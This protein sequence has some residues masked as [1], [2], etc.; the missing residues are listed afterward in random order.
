MAPMIVNQAAGDNEG[1][2]LPF[3]RQLRW[4]L[5]VSF[6]C[7]A[8]LPVGITEALTLPQAKEQAQ[9]QVFN[10]LTSVAELK[11]NQIARW[12]EDSQVALDF[13]LSSPLR[14]KLVALVADPSTSTDAQNDIN[15]I[16]KEEIAAQ[17]GDTDSGLRFRT[18]FVYTADGH[19]V[20]ASDGVIIGRVV[21]RQPYFAESLKGEYIQPPHYTVGTANLAM[22]VTQPVI[23]QQGQIVGV[24]AGELD[25][26]A[27]GKIMLARSGLGESGETYLVSVEN[28]YLLTPSRF[29]GYPLT[30]AY[31]SQGIDRALR[32]EEGS[33]VYTN[34]RDPFVSVFGVYRWVP[35]LQAALLTE[36]DVSE[37]LSSFLQ[38]RNLSIAMAAAAILAAI[39]F[40]LFTATRVSDPISTLTRMAAR[41][42]GGDLSQ[43]THI[44][45]R[46]EIG[47]LA[48]VFNTMT[49][50]LQETQ[51]SLERRV[52]ERTAEL[53]QALTDLE[54]TLAELR[55]TASAREQLSAAVREMSSPVVPVLEGILITPLIGIID[56]SRAA[57]L[58]RSLLEAIEQH[59]ASVVILD[60]TGVPLV[61]TQTARVL[62]DAA[63][64]ARL[65]GAESVL[66]GL[67]PELAQTIVGLGVDLSGLTTCADLQSGVSYAMEQRRNRRFRHS[68]P[69]SMLSGTHD[70]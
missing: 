7:L 39:A 56:S 13:L 33:G 3:W 38:A 63:S 47:L 20:A 60:V 69:R 32:G 9:Q 17:H 21:S 61:D 11:Q 36:I 4:S 14:D 52:A 34:Y 68:R 57:L 45:Q 18:L 27:L 54:R 65:L 48:S 46:N 6:V 5:I 43:R 59:R 41:I 8:V 55:E 44:A 49:S 30:R 1:A 26:A 37:A 15:S 58:V 19:I 64:A 22:F 50:Q 29:E 12:I 16:L 31:H 70:H 23:D 2:A 35:G 10:Q 53:E 25:L 62:L 67:R 24:L 42:A 51:E 28:N 40:G 66:V